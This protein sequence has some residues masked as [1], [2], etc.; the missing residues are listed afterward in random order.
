MDGWPCRRGDFRGRSVSK[1]RLRNRCLTNSFA[2]PIG[3]DGQAAREK[4]DTRLC[5]AP[6]NLPPPRA[7]G[8]GFSGPRRSPCPRARCAAIVAGLIHRCELA[9]DYPTIGDRKGSRSTNRFRSIAVS[10]G[11]LT[12][13]RRAVGVVEAFGGEV[14]PAFA[15]Q[16][17]GHTQECKRKLVRIRESLG[18]FCRFDMGRPRPGYHPA[19]RLDRCC[20]TAPSSE[21]TGLPGLGSPVRPRRRSD[22]ACL[23]RWAER[24]LHRCKWWYRD[25]RSNRGLVGCRG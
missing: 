12:A 22:R 13:R 11:A 14:L 6:E 24:A 1:V 3:L 18:D 2:A 20:S 19:C 23:C 9:Q 25:V 17:D 21:I 7:A 4:A 8:Y 10:V 16:A 15:A 5:S